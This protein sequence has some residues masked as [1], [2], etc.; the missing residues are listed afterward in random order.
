M[1]KIAFS[2]T[3]Y[4]KLWDLGILTDILRQLFGSRAY[5]HVACNNVSYCSKTFEAFDIDALS[6]REVFSLSCDRHQALNNHLHAALLQLRMIEQFVRGMRHCSENSHAPFTMNLHADAWPLSQEGVEGLLRHLT[7]TSKSFASSGRGFAYTNP[8]KLEGMVNDI[9]FVAKN[10]EVKDS[11]V[12]HFDYEDLLLLNPNIHATLAHMIK[13]RCGIRSLHWF[14]DL[15]ETLAWDGSTKVTTPRFSPLNYDPKRHFLHFDTKDF[16]GDY[17]YLILSKFLV[18]HGLNKGRYI[19]AHL[20]KY[21]FREHIID[22]YKDY[23]LKKFGKKNPQFIFQQSEKLAKMG[24]F[25]QKIEILKNKSLIKSAWNHSP[26]L[27]PIKRRW[28]PLKQ[29]IFGLD[30]KQADPKEGQYRENI[31]I[32]KEISRQ[33]NEGKDFEGSFVDKEKIPS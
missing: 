27:A 7:D 26:F 19:E 21:P 8:L 33:I 25:R 29:V 15:S 32:L 17:I 14:S 1:Q 31:L 10:S 20:K 6:I 5:I 28:T 22:E 2:I 13:Y 16:F 9:F 4:D 24:Y 12:F 30:A 3:V 18:D 11:G 23:L